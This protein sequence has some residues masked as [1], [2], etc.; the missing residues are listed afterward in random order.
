MTKS[1][2]KGPGVGL[3]Y[4]KTRSHKKRNSERN[5]QDQIEQIEKT[6]INDLPGK[7]LPP[8]GIELSSSNVEDEDV[9]DDTVAGVEA[10]ANLRV[11][12]L[13]KSPV[14]TAPLCHLLLVYGKI[15]WPGR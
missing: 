3:R 12:M 8:D 9:G 15:Q 1:F 6:L 11:A 7:T 5:C 14:C 10:D 2:R 13:K 4:K